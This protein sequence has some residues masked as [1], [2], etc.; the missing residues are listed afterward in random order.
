MTALRKF[1][2]DYQEYQSQLDHEAWKD[3]AREEFYTDC[4]KIY[5]RCQHLIDEDCKLDVND[6]LEIAKAI[7]DIMDLSVDYIYKS[8]EDGELAYAFIQEGIYV[9]RDELGYE[10]EVIF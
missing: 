9:L 6:S 8:D 4:K 3:D 1:S 5:L 10:W 2:K 7:Q